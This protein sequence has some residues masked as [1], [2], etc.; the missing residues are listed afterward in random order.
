M[1]KQ[2]FLDAAARKNPPGQFALGTGT[3][4]VCQDLMRETGVSFP[5]AH[6]DAEAMAA[7]AI[8]GH[9]V[10]GLDVVMPLFSVCHEAAAL[11]CN[12]QW[13]GPDAMPESGQPIWSRPAD[14][15]IPPGFL[16]HPACRTPL[17]AISLLKKRLGDSAAVC[18]K[19]FGGWTL[20]YHL[21]GVENFLMG[22]LD[23]PA[24]TREI[25]E[26]LTPAT[27]AF[28]RAQIEAG[29]DCILLADHATRDLCSPAAY[30]DF[31][32]G[33]HTRLAKEIP[34]PVILHICGNTSDRIGMI[35]Q[36]GLAGFHW[37]TKTGSPAEVR[38]LAGERMSL[39]GGVSNLML[40]NGKPEEVTTAA[41]AAARAGIDIVGPECAVPLRTPLANLKA[42]AA[43][44]G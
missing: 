34:A 28:A 35:A 27:L 18:G 32:Q 23:D 1:S 37:D 7:L 40:L 22:T 17:R 9:T 42:I 13:G 26:R 20:G 25:I 39:M 19:A 11:G 43:C 8:A 33:L 24:G 44:R 16:D 38:R 31:L 36:T 14:V 5:Q 3:S 21:F 10:L 15:R 30:R 12:V 6:L 4:I 29:A 41:R 2:T